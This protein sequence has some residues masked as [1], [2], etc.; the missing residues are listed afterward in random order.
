[1]LIT[2]ENGMIEL[3]PALP[4]SFGISGE[5]KDIVVRSA[6]ISFKWR[7][8]LV[9]EICSSKPVTILDKRLSKS[10]IAGENINI[11]GNE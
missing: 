7:N 2:E 9:T 5:V 1:M 11:K 8:G 3:I 6:K 4:E 10:L